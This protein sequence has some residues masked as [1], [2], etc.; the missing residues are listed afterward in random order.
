LYFLPG[1]EGL[2]ASRIRA[3]K[4][5]VSKLKRMRRLAALLA[6][7]PYLRMLG[8]TGSLA[9]KNGTR[10]SDWDMFVVGSDGRF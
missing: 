3:E 5:S 4:I 10:E 8:A 1:R 2:I 9:M 6:Y 7:I